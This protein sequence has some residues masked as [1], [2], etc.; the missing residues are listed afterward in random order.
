[1]TSPIPERVAILEHKVERINVVESKLDRLDE[2]LDTVLLELAKHRGTSPAAPVGWT[3]SRTAQQTVG[4]VIGAGLLYIIQ[5]V[6]G[7]TMPATAPQPSASHEPAH[8]QTHE[9]P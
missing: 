8:Q 5:A 4:G 2:K 6:A 9:G 7:A 1:M 3:I